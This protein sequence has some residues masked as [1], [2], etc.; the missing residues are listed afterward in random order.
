MHFHT[1]IMC[2]HE[3][4]CRVDCSCIQTLHVDFHTY[5]STEIVHSAHRN[6]YNIDSTSLTTQ[7][8]T[9]YKTILTLNLHVHIAMFE[10]D[11]NPACAHYQ[12][13]YVGGIPLTAM[14]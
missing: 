11:D 10:D 3:L 4:I 8:P 5:T 12:D 9:E 13:G 7:P 1:H 6:L 2:A 14:A